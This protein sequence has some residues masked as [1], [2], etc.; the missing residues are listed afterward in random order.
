M[1]RTLNRSDALLNSSLLPALYADTPIHAPAYLAFLN[2]FEGGAGSFSPFQ[3]DASGPPPG[4]MG[5]G[6]FV[7]FDGHFYSGV[8]VPVPPCTLLD[9]VSTSLGAQLAK[10]GLCAQ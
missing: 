2:L 3:T 6:H 1:L 4:H 9:S 8:G 7:R 10:V 5:N